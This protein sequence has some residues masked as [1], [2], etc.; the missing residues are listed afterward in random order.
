MSKMT[1]AGRKVPGN[2]HPNSIPPIGRRG[3]TVVKTVDYQPRF[4]FGWCR[5]G[6][7]TVD[8]EGLTL[9][10]VLQTF[11][12]AWRHNCSGEAWYWLFV[13]DGQPIVNDTD[14]LLEQMDA[15]NLGD[16]PFVELQLRAG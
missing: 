4:G 12:D 6:A 8:Y 16:I 13:Y 14:D 11:R 1:L 9:P 10:E 5:S 15:A 7:P 2:P 3:V